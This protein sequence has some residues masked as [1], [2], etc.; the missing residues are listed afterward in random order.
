MHFLSANHLSL[1]NKLE[2][3]NKLQYKAQFYLWLP[4]LESPFYSTN[5]FS[6]MEL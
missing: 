2:K 6:D 4:L 5:T 1:D 3:Q